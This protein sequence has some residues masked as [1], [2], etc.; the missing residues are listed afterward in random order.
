MIEFVGGALS[1]SD[2]RAAAQGIRDAISAG[3]LSEPG[4]V[5][6]LTG[7]GYDVLIAARE[8]HDAGYTDH[9]WLAS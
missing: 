1:A 3:E 5:T 8:T 7:W 2:A 4:I 6:P 9:A